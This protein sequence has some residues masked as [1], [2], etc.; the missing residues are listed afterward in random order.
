MTGRHPGGPGSG[1]LDGIGTM[2]GHR[3]SRTA[4]NAASGAAAGVGNVL[5][6]GRTMVE[7]LHLAIRTIRVVAPDPRG[8]V[9][10]VWLCRLGQPSYFEVLSQE[11]QISR[12]SLSEETS[13]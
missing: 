9:R 1:R 13:C 8:V 2:T 5:C 6:I 10:T 11:A 4:D 12:G 3:S 7:V